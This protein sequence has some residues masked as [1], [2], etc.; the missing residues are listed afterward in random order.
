MEQIIFRP[1]LYK[2][3]TLKAFTDE[4]KVGGSDLILT[5]KYIYDPYSDNN[6]CGAQMIYQRNSAAASL[7]TPWLTR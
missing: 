4:F 3:D 1:K 5:N 2:F 6:K 7:P